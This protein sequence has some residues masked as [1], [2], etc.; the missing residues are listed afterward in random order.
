MRKTTQLLQSLGKKP[1]VIAVIL[2]T[3]ILLLLAGTKAMQINSMISAGKNFVPPPESVTTAK[4]SFESW[5]ITV[6]TVGSLAAVRG[7]TVAAEQGGTIA[8][9]VFNPGGVVNAGDLLVQQDISTEEAQ[10]REAL[11]TA[12]L[13]KINLKRSKDLLNRN[14]TSK[15]EYDAASSQHKGAIARV[16]SIRSLI[17]K[18][19]IRA[20]FAGKVGIQKVYIG[21]YLQA[22]DPV[23][24][25]QSLDPMYANFMVPQQKTTNIVK[26]LP[27][28]IETDVQPG[29][30]FN[31]EISAVDPEIDVN[32]RNA[33]VQAILANSE[34][35][36]LPGMFVNVSI[37]LPN[38]N[39]ILVIPATAV[40]HA[41]YGASVFVVEEQVDNES[42]TSILVARQQFIKLGKTKG[43]YIA[44]TSGLENE[45]IIVTTGAFKLY[46]GQPI[47]ANN[48]LAPNFELE[49]DP[50]D[51]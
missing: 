23:V 17:D 46:S 28:R 44:V 6:E 9:I 39:K 49:P 5:K 33:A 15:S 4:V 35:Q 37:I 29:K 13:T 51:S 47:V 26:G 43:D 40:V 1:I 41:P 32:T 10:L 48:K 3:G 12:E 25:L 22:G 36:L 11:A 24:S 18:K 30:I 27:V 45:Q 14:L 20:P 50:I 38:Q 19:S 8:E 34:E 21:Q 42:N 7:V 31:G 16:D 2:L